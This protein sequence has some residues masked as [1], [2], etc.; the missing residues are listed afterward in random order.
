MAGTIL[1]LSV[2]FFMLACSPRV[3]QVLENTKG[4]RIMAFPP[5]GTAVIMYPTP[6][7][8][9]SSASTLTQLLSLFSPCSAR[10]APSYRLIT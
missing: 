2:S 9:V 6:G 8:N 10:N 7:C 4:I 5:T 1:R 3:V